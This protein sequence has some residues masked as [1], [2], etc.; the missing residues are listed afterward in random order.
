M[1][2]ANVDTFSPKSGLI[3]PQI[4]KTSPPDVEIFP[5][6]P[7]FRNNTNHIVKFNLIYTHILLNITEFRRFLTLK[8]MG[9]EK[10]GMRDPPDLSP[11][12]LT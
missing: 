5:L 3:L 2:N 12:L 11:S 7:T 1:I 9:Q 8:V 6:Q 10:I 4:V